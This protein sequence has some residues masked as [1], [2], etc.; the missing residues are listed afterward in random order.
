MYVWMNEK[1]IVTL[2]HNSDFFLA[3]LILYLTILRIKRI[4]RYNSELQ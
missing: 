1:V 3:I 4:V 2:S